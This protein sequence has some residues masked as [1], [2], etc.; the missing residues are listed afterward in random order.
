MCISGRF[1]DPSAPDCVVEE[2]RG[3]RAVAQLPRCGLGVPAPCWRIDVDP[4]CGR[5]PALL[6][7]RAGTP[8]PP[9]TVARVSCA[10][11]C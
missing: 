8:A 3:G 9:H 5:D 2:V 1:A 6:I 7:D 11:S 10:V 4:A